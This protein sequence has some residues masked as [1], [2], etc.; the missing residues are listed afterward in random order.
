MYRT[1]TRRYFTP[2]ENAM[3]LGIDGTNKSLTLLVQSI[4]R[5]HNAVINRY[6]RLGQVLPGKN[7]FSPL[8]N[9]II[10]DNV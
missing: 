6:K 7:E 2:E 4:G 9:Q 10:L 1:F 8:D 3:I 5:H